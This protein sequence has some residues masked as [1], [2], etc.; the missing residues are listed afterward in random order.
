MLPSLNWFQ[1]DL[2]IWAPNIGGSILFFASGYLAFIETCHAHWAWHPRSVSWWLVFAN[3]LGCLAFLISALFAFVLPGPENAVA[4]TRSVT[5]TL[6]GAIGFLV[7][8]LLMLP[9]A[10]LTPEPSSPTVQ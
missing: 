9:E 5:F 8:L 2:L 7:G 10:S 3:F 4:V 1:R 6:L